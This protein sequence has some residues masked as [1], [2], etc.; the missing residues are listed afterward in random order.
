MSAS[1]SKKNRAA[2]LEAG[3]SRKQLLAEKEAAAKIK[4]KRIRGVVS[5]L[6]AIVVVIVIL[7]NTSFFYRNATA[8]T[9]GDEKYT[10]AEL[11]YY[12]AAQYYSFV[13]QYGSYASIFGLYASH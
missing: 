5:V 3:P 4:S 8:V 13:D 6:V 10:P 11:Q 7:F 12:L 2:E 9:I 1:T